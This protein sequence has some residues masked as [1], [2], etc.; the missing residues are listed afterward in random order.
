ML[1]DY[2]VSVILGARDIE[3]AKKFYTEKLGLE[4]MERK[5]IPEDAFMV[6]AGAGSTIFVYHTD[7]A[8]AQAT[9]AGFSIE[10]GSLEDEVARLAEKG[11]KCEQFHMPGLKQNDMGI[12]EM[13]G[14][15]SAW[16]KDPEGN[17]IALNQM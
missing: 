7:F 1:K 14:V 2:K 15:K 12:T 9:A 17:T 10:S 8:P 16:I 13:G 11:V 3:R 6:K 5:G 4:L